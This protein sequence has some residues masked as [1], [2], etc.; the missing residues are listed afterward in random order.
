M[1]PE[2]VTALA[3]AAGVIATAL[4]ALATFLA[5]VAALAIAIWGDWLKSLTS[6]PRLAISISM[7]APDC[8]KI[9][10]TQLLQLPG[11][12]QPIQAATFDT[13][14]FRLFVGNDGNAA[15]RNVGVRAIRLSKLNPKSGVYYEDPHFMSMDLTWSHA[16]GSVV[17]AK[18]DPKLPLINW[19][20]CRQ[21]F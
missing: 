12:A 3:T 1:S 18:I 14:Y 8:H 13:Y 15:A 20:A 6:R 4:G 10:T 16:G 11:V 5:V 7:K 9:Q 19:G 2:W 17:V 21:S